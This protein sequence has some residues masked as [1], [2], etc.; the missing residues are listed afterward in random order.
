MVRHNNERTFDLFWDMAVKIELKA[1]KNV[2]GKAEKN[3][4]EFVDK[5]IHTELFSFLFFC[6]YLLG[7]SFAVSRFLQ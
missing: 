5:I 2:N 6:F 1:Q 3:K 7:V 4:D